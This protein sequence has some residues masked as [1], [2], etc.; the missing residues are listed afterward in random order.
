MVIE[1]LAFSLFQTNQSFEQH[2]ANLHWISVEY[3]F[4]SRFAVV[5]I[6]EKSQTVNSKTLILG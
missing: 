5:T 2:F 1:Q 6:L 4:T 3:R